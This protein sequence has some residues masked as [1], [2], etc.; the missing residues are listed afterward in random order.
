MDERS[1]YTQDIHFSKRGA[2]L[3]LIILTIIIFGAFYA[4]S[5][6]KTTI[7]VS[8][9]Q[10]HTTQTA[11]KLPNSG[12]Y[13]AYPKGSTGPWVSFEGKIYK[14]T[15]DNQLVED[16]SDN[17]L[18]EL[19]WSPLVENL[20]EG[21]RLF[22]VIQ[23][24][25][26]DSSYVILAI[27]DK[28]NTRMDFGLYTHSKDAGINLIRKFSRTD[29]DIVSQQ[30]STDIYYIP[31][32]LELFENGILMISLLKCYDCDA[33]SFPHYVLYNP[34]TDQFSYI[35]PAANFQWIGD[36]KYRYTLHG[37][38][39]VTDEDLEYCSYES[40]T[41]E[42]IEKTRISQLQADG[43]QEFIYGTLK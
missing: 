14:Y 19:V 18:K 38:V 32:K 1:V 3:I 39:Q 25:L 35:G 40:N 6:Y 9:D 41:E 15:H 20:P 31:D 36:G 13:I 33:N 11:N 30:D 29:D 17:S 42:C 24:P 21:A 16:I 5:I 27:P 22:D 10:N 8:P 2:V 37:E 34:A 4:G 7:S 26:K 28:D 12:L 43:K 23:M